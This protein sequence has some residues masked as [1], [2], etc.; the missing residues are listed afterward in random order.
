MARR[1]Q[2]VFGRV[3]ILVNNAGGNINSA[4]RRAPLLELSLEEWEACLALNLTSVFLCSR[5]VVPMMKQQKKG[6]I[7]N[8]GSGREGDASRTGF[9][10]YGAAKGGVARLTSGVAAEW[11]P[12]VRVNCVLPGFVDNPKPTP[13][14]TP[15][16]VAERARSIAVG[17]IGQPEDI[18]AAV[19][20]L[21]SDAASWVDGILLSVHGGA[22]SQG[23]FGLPA[24]GAAFKLPER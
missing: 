15:E 16:A 20:F 9:S 12:E 18:G 11:G 19:A 3:D 6:A 13:G 7:I 24:G 22:I 23:P 2:E 14:R 21:A 4:F 10:A 5:A 8:I 17:R 1:T